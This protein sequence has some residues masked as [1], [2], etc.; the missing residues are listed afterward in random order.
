[1][2]Y[3]V[4]S[5]FYPSLNKNEIK[6]FGLLAMIFFFIIGTYW[7]VRLLKD[8]LL[9][10]IAFPECLGWPAGYGRLMQPVCKIWSPFVVVL[11]VLIYSKLVDLF[12]KHKLFYLI[13]SFYAVLFFSI[14]IVL[15][16]RAI[17]GELYL[18][19]TILAT[20]GFISYFATES[21]GSLLAALFW[22]FTASVSTN[23]EAKKGFPLII[24]GA[25]LG[26]IGGSSLTLFAEQIGGIWKLFIF[27]S[28][29]ILLIIVMMYYFIKTM[30][31]DQLIGDKHAAQTEKIKEGFFEGFV[32][33]LKL[34]LTRSYLFGILI[35]STFYEAANQIID[36]QMKSQAD[37]YPGFSGELGF[38]KFQGIYGVCT[39]ILAFLM[40]LLGTSYL[41]KRLGTRICLLIFPIS[42]AISFSTLYWFYRFGNLTAGELL[43]ATFLTMMVSRALSYAV[44]NPTKDMMYIPTSKD[45]KFKTKGWID[46]F[47]SRSAKMA[48]ARVSNVFKHSLTDLMRYGTLFSLGLIGCWLFA[49]I[50][51]GK[52]N[53]ELVK[54][55]EII[56]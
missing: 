43:F 39:N 26:G 48:G 6:K 30:P 49:A 3:K 51:V 21:F 1:M 27:A 8:T 14:G 38:A 11:I 33:G 24:A 32:S 55:G 40:A 2:V 45:A 54:N 31:K 4:I 22:S 35:I 15:G 19:S 25:Q 10:K 56:E 28:I 41:I 18:G 52:R 46:M 13:C 12:E 17:C 16:I 47:G 7:L 23:E 20:T 36:Y 34:L 29:F 44:N 50:Y 37:L 5:F 42:L 9:F 53:E